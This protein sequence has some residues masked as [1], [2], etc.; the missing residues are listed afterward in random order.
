MSVRSNAYVDGWQNWALRSRSIL[1]IGI[2][3]GDFAVA[4]GK[5]IAAGHLHAPAVLLRPGE[6]PF[7]HSTIARDEMPAVRP[8]RVMKCFEHCGV[9]GANSLLPLAPLS[10][11]LR[12][13][14]CFEHTVVCH[15]RHQRIEIV[16]IP[17]V[18][19]AVQQR[20]YIHL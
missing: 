16:S 14:R 2:L 9:C 10:V 6:R 3:D 12:T 17:R 13:G 8:V 1:P 19:E 20:E 4:E 5:E 18:G 15:H 11:D 7:R